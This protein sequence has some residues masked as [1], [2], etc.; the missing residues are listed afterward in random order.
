MPTSS[1]RASRRRQGH[2][3]GDR[4][5]RRRPRGTS[6][7]GE[8][9]ARGEGPKKKEKSAEDEKAQKEKEL[10]KKAKRTPRRPRK[11]PR[12]T[13][14]PTPAKKEDETAKKKAEE[15]AKKKKAEEDKKK[16]EE[17]EAKKKSDEEAK[18]KA[19][20]RPRRRSSRPTS[21]AAKAF[22][23]VGQGQGHQGREGDDCRLRHPRRAKAR[24][25]HKTLTKVH[26]KDFRQDLGN[27]LR[28]QGRWRREAGRRA[29]YR[30]EGDPHKDLNNNPKLKVEF[31]N[32]LAAAIMKNVGAY[33]AAVFEVSDKVAAYLEKRHAD[34]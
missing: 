23:G 5:G 16:A 20:R 17:V 7:Q 18:K 31:E 26:V 13:R 9:G 8:P 33:K 34:A 1:R 27:A 11:R 3:V 25:Q 4:Q 22:V 12:A 10:A 14:S 24:E 15:D 32:A 6:R 21:I 29:R 28:G 30:G 2:Q 19:T